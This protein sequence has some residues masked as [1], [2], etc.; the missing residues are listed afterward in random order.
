MHTLA[1]GVLSVPAQT[2][3]FWFVYGL[4]ETSWAREQGRVTRGGMQVARDVW[5]RRIGRLGEIV[6]R[7]KIDNRSQDRAGLIPHEPASTTLTINHTSERLIQH[8]RV[9]L[10]TQTKTN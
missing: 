1:I 2:R 4:E 10:P 8:M 6:N 7:S 9:S 5:Y 3:K